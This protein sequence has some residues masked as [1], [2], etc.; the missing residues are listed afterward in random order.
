MQDA[1]VKVGTATKAILVSRLLSQW[2]MGLFVDSEDKS[3]PSVSA[4]KLCVVDELAQLPSFESV[5]AWSKDL[6]VL[7]DFTFMDLYTY[8]VESKDKSYDKESLTE[9]FKSLVF[10]RWVCTECMDSWATHWQ[11]TQSPLPLLCIINSQE[12]LHCLCVYES[13]GHCLFG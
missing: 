10:Q 9:S 11:I 6:R 12:N 5:S 2:Q 8:L 3:A 13:Q 4:L 7:S 1:K